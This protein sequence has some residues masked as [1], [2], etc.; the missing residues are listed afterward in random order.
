MLI[1]PGPWHMMK[2]H[3]MQEDS[4]TVLLL[5]K[6]YHH[7]M[8]DRSDLDLVWGWRVVV[9]NYHGKLYAQLTQ[10]GKQSVALH[11]HLMGLGIDKAYERDGSSLVVHH[12]NGNG[13]DNRRE[14]LEIVTQSENMRRKKP[15]RSGVVGVRQSADGKKW[16]SSICHNG[17]NHHLGTFQ[18]K[19]EAREAY[20]KAYHEIDS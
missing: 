9:V 17:K 3:H 14:N 15:G 19:D 5:N 2:G 6:H 18:T 10:P 13:L 7:V 20:L 16:T 8:I 4:T 11:R 1:H 12:K